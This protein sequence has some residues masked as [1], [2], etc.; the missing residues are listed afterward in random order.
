[1]YRVIDINKI[2]ELFFDN[3]DGKF[4]IR[5]IA[6]RTNL[7]PNTVLKEVKALE[8]DTL[9]IVQKTRAVK[10]VRVNK[11][12]ELFFVLKKIRNLSC[13]Y[14]SG[15][16]DNLNKEYNYPE[17]IVLFGSYSRGEDTGKSDIDIAIITQNEL[18]LDLRKFE[19][20]LG[21]KIQV[22]EINLNKV[23]KTFVTTLVN[24][25][26]LKGYLNI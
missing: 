25:I 9:L 24:G 26:V 19:K 15:L 16:V 12:N 1:M 7:H 21:R 11:D 8:K 2:L 4:H 14:L 23:G 5:E 3:P 6:R 20:T 18:E 13:L 17:A 10:E 22:H